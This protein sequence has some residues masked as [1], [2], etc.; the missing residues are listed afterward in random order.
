MRTALRRYWPAL[1]AIAHLVLAALYGVIN[2]PYEANDETG[3]FGFVNHVV[4]A[5]SLPDATREDNRSLL[6]Q[7][8]QPPLYYVLQAV[9]TGWID[10]SDG[11]TPTPNVFAFDGTNRRGVRLL[12]RSPSEGCLLYTSPS[13]RD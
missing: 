9:L 5:K 7:S 2:P 12:L 6:D 1:L 3:H 11:Q 8:H 13:P 4:A 10:R